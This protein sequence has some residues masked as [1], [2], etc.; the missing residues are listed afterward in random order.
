MARESIIKYIISYFFEGYHRYVYDNYFFSKDDK[1]Y[2]KP[3]IGSWLVLR[4]YAI[5]FHIVYSDFREY[6]NWWHTE[7]RNRYVR[8][9]KYE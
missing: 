9:K 1:R 5:L 2:K 3:T 4:I 8:Y 6:L 7:F